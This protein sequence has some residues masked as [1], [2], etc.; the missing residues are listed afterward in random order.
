MVLSSLINA[1]VLQVTVVSRMSRK[2]LYCMGRQ[3]LLS[4]ETKRPAEIIYLT[5]RASLSR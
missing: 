3:Q 5:L 1:S 2:N 4:L